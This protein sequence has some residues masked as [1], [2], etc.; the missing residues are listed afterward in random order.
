MLPP[1]DLPAAAGDLAAQ[2]AALDRRAHL[3]TKLRLR[4]PAIA[5]VA[6]AIEADEAAA[7]PV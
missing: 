1:A 5:A 4:A 6:A 2:L 7:V 3:E